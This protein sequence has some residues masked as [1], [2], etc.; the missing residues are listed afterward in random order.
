M[1]YHSTHAIRTGFPWS[2]TI[3]LMICCADLNAEA[4]GSI[5]YMSS[6]TLPVIVE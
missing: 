5:S 1:F 2:L 3:S 6:P 4:F